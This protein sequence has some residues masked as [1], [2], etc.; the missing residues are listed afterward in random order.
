[1][2]TVLLLLT[3]L[4][5]LAASS[6]A[7]RSA[8]K[9]SRMLSRPWQK[10][11]AAILQTET[12]QLVRQPRSG[13]GSST[14]LYFVQT[15]FAAGCALAVFGYVLTNIDEIKAKQEVAMKKAVAEQSS[16]IQTAQETQRRAIADAQA[17]QKAAIDKIKNMKR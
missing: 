11:P 3:L 8:S 4:V 10:P 17:K 9:S 5:A 1:M 16:T 13:K 2:T 15:I 6:Q 14:S 12:P 7:L